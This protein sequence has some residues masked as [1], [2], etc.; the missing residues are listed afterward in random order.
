[1]A[2]YG[3]EIQEGLVNFKEM[4]PVKQLECVTVIASME[5]QVDTLLKLEKD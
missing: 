4:N 1:M 3:P 5:N 2:E